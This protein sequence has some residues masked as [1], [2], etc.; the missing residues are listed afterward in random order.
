MRKVLSILLFLGGMAAAQSH[1]L[2]LRAGMLLDGK[3]GVQHNV[4][5][6]VQD[7]KIQSVAPDKG[8]AADYDLSGYTVMPGWIDAHVHITW[9][10]GPNGRLAEEKS[11]SPARATLAAESNA[12]KTLLA[13]FTMVQSV[14]SPDDKALRDAIDEKLVPGPRILT[15][16]EP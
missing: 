7:G 10:F 13:G 12:W 5:I 1:P 2:T 15:S 6:T 3:G 16:L 11:E 9:H 14:G 8:G 4:R